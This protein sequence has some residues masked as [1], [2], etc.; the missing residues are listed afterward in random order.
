MKT[1]VIPEALNL[2]VDYYHGFLYYDDIAKGSVFMARAY[3]YLD[4]MVFVA[5][6]SMKGTRFID[7]GMDITRIGEKGLWFS[8]ATIYSERF[9]AQ[10]FRFKNLMRVTYKIGYIL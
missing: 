10:T 9:I 1:R 6:Q 2:G 5:M 8:K 7:V 3:G 4:N